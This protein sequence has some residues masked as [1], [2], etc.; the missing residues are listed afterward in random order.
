MDPLYHLQFGCFLFMIISAA[1]LLLGALHTQWRNLRYEH[2]RHLIIVALLILAA[3]YF[4]QMS[5]GIRATDDTYGA[6][7]NA[8]VYPVC[9]SFISMGIYHIEATHSRRRLMNFV[10]LCF[11]LVIWLVC[12]IGYQLKGGPNIGEWLYVAQAIFLASVVYDIVMITKEMRKRRKMLETMAATDMLPY[13]R[14]SQVSLFTLF[15]AALVMPIAII[16]TQLLM[17]VGP[18]VLIALLFFLVTFQA[19]GCN[20]VP[21]EELLDE[22]VERVVALSPEEKRLGGAI[23]EELKQ[24]IAKKLDAWCAEEG[25]KDTAINLLMLSRQLGISKSD[26]SLYFDQCL[27][28]NFRVWLSDIRFE[29]AKKMMQD[30]PTFSNDVISAEC[31]FSS[32]SQLYRIFNAKVGCS[33]NVWRNTRGNGI[34]C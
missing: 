1:Y 7:V 4:A 14:Y 3:Q 29:A 8:L 19:L 17:I 24:Q 5:L 21:S 33:P 11:C 22:E 28:S 16:S 18:L 13:V 30:N 34:K 20:Y 27:K 23:S 9:F 32:R 26:L 12:G 15:A 31:G 25:Y 10:C 6:L 2:S